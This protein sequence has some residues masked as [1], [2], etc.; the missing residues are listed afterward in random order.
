MWASCA[1]IAIEGTGL[2]TG[3]VHNGRDVICGSGDASRRSAATASTA[4][5]ADGSEAV[6]PTSPE[7]GN[8]RLVEPVATHARP[9]R[10]HRLVGGRHG[11]LGGVT[12]DR[13]LGG[14]G[15]DFVS[16]TRGS[17]VVT[18]A[19]DRLRILKGADD[20]RRRGNDFCLSVQD[21]DPGDFIDG[22]PGLTI[23][24]PI[25]P[26]RGST[27]VGPR[28]RATG[29]ETYEYGRWPVRRRRSCRLH[30]HRCRLEPPPHHH[31]RVHRRRPRVAGL[32]PAARRNADG[33]GLDFRPMLPGG[34][35]AS[36]DLAI[37]LEHRCQDRARAVSSPR[38]GPHQ[39]AAASATPATRGFPTSNH[40]LDAGAAVSALPRCARRHGLTHGERRTERCLARSFAIRWRC[41]RGHLAYTFGFNGLHEDAW[42][43]KPHRPMH[44]REGRTGAPG[45]APTWSQACIGQSLSHA[46]S[47]QGRTASFPRATST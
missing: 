9:V 7:E 10:Q 37:H 21:G 44:H 47:P 24:T 1:G 23:S 30:L 33:H 2:T 28:L 43:G 40:T 26:T 18:W 5:R 19:R 20:R 17:D 31:D 42:M 34:G 38:H 35:R 25:A 39:L 22:G 4:A 11:L 36:A 27:Q 13:Y 6:Q 32:W 16:D 29:A 45:R 15:D 46:V 12:D 8:D 3:F 41:G 14:D